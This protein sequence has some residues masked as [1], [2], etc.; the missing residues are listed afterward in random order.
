M[1]ETVSE[2][3]RTILSN[4]SKQKSNLSNRNL[5]L[6]Y[7]NHLMKSINGTSFLHLCTSQGVAHLFSK[8]VFHKT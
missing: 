7:V 3:F 1:L 5:T 6:R 8:S 2:H 4:S